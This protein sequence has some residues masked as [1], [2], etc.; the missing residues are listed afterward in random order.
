MR[1]EVFCCMFWVR[2]S[3]LFGWIR[4]TVAQCL[5]DRSPAFIFCGCD[6]VVISTEKLLLDMSRDM[7]SDELGVQQ[8]YLCQYA[9]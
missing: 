7:S 8:H 1:Y 5:D 6:I 2:K 9:V 3:L 4:L